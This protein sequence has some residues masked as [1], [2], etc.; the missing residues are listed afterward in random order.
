MFGQ[1]RAAPAMENADWT[2]L[3]IPVAAVVVRGVD[4]NAGHEQRQHQHWNDRTDYPQHS[5]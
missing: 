2:I 3:L 4:T 5:L 1:Q